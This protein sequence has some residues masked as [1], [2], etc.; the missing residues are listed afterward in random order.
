MSDDSEL[1]ISALRKKRAD[2]LAKPAAVTHEMTVHPTLIETHP[3]QPAVH[4]EEPQAG[5]TGG[6]RGRGDFDA[7]EKVNLPFDPWR[8]PEALRQ[9]WY[10]LVLA[11]MMLGLLGGAYGYWRAEYKIH[12]TLVLRDL[13]SRAL[14]GTQ[15]D[16]GYK[17]PQLSSQTLI[18]FLTSAGLIR[19][20]SSNASPP[21][22]EKKLASSLVVTQEKSSE[23]I[24][25]TMSGKDS[26]ALVSLANLYGTNAVELSKLAQME[27][28][29]LTFVVCSNKLNDA[30]IQ[31]TN[32]YAELALF[33][34]N[35]NIIDPE[36][37]RLAYVR[38]SINTKVDL[39]KAVAERDLVAQK[40][41]VMRT[42]P[43]IKSLKEQED[44]LNALL[45]AGKLDEYPDVKRTRAEI[46]RL[47]QQLAAAANGS[48][49]NLM[50]GQSVEST[51]H[52]NLLNL[53]I[54]ELEKRAG[55]LDK[56]V[57]NINE[58][59]AE[60]AR[61]KAG[62]EF[63]EKWQKT[64]QKRE[65][66]ALQYLDSA[67]GYYKMS[68]PAVEKDV[69]SRNRKVKSVLFAFGAGVLGVFLSTML[70]LVIEVADPRLKTAADVRR[71]TNLPVLA[72]LGDLDKMDA[73]ARKAWAFRTW[74]ILSGTLSQSSNRGTVCGFLSCAHGEGRTTWVEM[75]VDAARERGF[76]VTKLDFGTAFEEMKADQAQGGT[77]S[78]PTTPPA[79]NTS[80]GSASTS[81][82]PGAASSAVATTQGS[83]QK[84]TQAK[85]ASVIHVQLPGLVWDLER[86]IQFQ[87][88]LVKW[89]SVSQAVVLVDLPP[90]SMPEAILL[91]ENLPQVIWLVDS[92][93]PHAR[94]TRMHLE[95]LRHA[96]CK[97]VGTVLNHEPEPLIK[98]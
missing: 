23:T 86:R 75:L 72:A 22:T 69:D 48:G 47:H 90:A 30:Q 9:R 81:S 54:V 19:A 31:L 62:I 1:S 43:L 73:R 78:K 8:L 91:A 59:V 84:L 12:F 85:A 49:T 39:D 74:T 3:V 61:I 83:S 82:S 16:G 63:Q 65:F 20:V 7:E 45:G 57:R 44:K 24:N 32:Y 18:N 29:K 40:N 93:K 50:S 89:R 15:D 6:G 52:T 10:W 36:I 25:I 80:V 5:P 46:E 94:E 76:E 38:E 92:G 95:T 28:P 64:V 34:T 98:L 35:A 87:E 66:E 77:E 14:P 68:G 17:P 13:S 37:E 97:L 79:Q 53:Q 51:V 4:R 96:R 58:H 70:V 26:R 55:D 56:K 11:G 88:E 67:E 27:D 71:V 41:E 21:I 2:M 42:E 33:R 60:Y